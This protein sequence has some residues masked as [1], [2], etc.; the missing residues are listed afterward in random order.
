[1]PSKGTSGKS[2]LAAAPAIVGW[3]VF[4]RDDKKYGIDAATLKIWLEKLFNILG[5]KLTDIT[6]D[7]DGALIKA[8]REIFPGI[9]IHMDH[10]HKGRHVNDA[11]LE[12]CKDKN[13]LTPAEQVHVDSGNQL[14]RLYYKSG[15]LQQ[16]L[17]LQVTIL[18]KIKEGTKLY[19]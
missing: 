4:R 14:W 17:N 15:S 11:A 10:I 9:N 5:V 6:C 19:H 2:R 13:N 12:D 1:M 7:E 18:S 8:I 3:L 16:A